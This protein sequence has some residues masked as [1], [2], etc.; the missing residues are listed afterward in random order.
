MSDF[1]ELDL[2]SLSEEELRAEIRRVEEALDSD[3]KTD[4]SRRRAIVGYLKRVNEELGR[5][6][7]SRSGNGGSAVS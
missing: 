2:P 5:R 1:G 6:R 3:D 4:A 7:G